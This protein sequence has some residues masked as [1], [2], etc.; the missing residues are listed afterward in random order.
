[1]KS[2]GPV[3]AALFALAGAAGPL[4]C[5]SWSAAPPCG[6]ALPSERFPV[7]HLAAV[8]RTPGA[9]P[10][11][12]GSRLVV[13]GPRGHTELDVATGKPIRVVSKPPFAWIP[14]ASRDDLWIGQDDSGHVV[15]VDPGPLAER[16]QVACTEGS[17]RCNVRGARAGGVVVFAGV[18]DER[19]GNTGV[20]AVDAWTGDELWRTAPFS[21]DLL[22]MDLSADAEHV[23]VTDSQVLHVFKSATGEE[24]WTR[25]L[26]STLPVPMRARPVAVERGVVA[27]W[28]GARRGRI[29]L[30]D[31]ESGDE[32]AVIPWPRMAGDMALE[33]GVLYVVSFW[34]GEGMD[35]AAFEA[36]TGQEKWRARTPYQWVLPPMAVAEDAIFLVRAGDSN[37]AL[38]DR[39]TE[40]VAL[41]KQSGREAFFHPA[42]RVNRLA[43]LPWSARG[44][45]LAFEAPTGEVIG[46]ARRAAPPSPV[47]V[48]ISGSV[49]SKVEDPLDLRGLRVEVGSAVVT[50]DAEGE[51][52]ARVSALGA[53]KV[54]LLDLPALPQ[55]RSGPPLRSEPVLL[56]VGGE[57]EE[58]EPGE[59]RL[60]APL[61]VEFVSPWPRD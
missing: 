51:F 24:A 19:T 1:M 26:Q 37:M 43:L 48:V 18:I 44:S 29:L 33:G 21:A 27:L 23:L 17:T 45:L 13:Q 12:L 32:H 36:K 41:D 14:E 16:W 9:A 5:H 2:W 35:V 25:A 3:L 53:V 55:P 30:L 20:F 46:M 50:T 61:A 59:R 7:S 11:F 39:G 38:N 22:S 28:E 15:G 49:T 34:D 54:Q 10:V 58:S 8:W 56:Y 42:G 4:A 31:A 40:I 60:E 52:S 47:E 6:G 57:G